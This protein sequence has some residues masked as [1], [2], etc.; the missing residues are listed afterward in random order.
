MA[1]QDEVTKYLATLALEQRERTSDLEARNEAVLEKKL[2]DLEVGPACSKAAGKSQ[3]ENEGPSGIIAGDSGRSTIV[4]PSEPEVVF[5]SD[6]EAPPLQP[7]QRDGGV[8]GAYAVAGTL[9][10]E[11][12]Q[13]P[14]DGSAAD[15]RRSL[16]QSAAPENSGLVEA[17]EVTDRA[18]DELQEAERVARSTEQPKRNFP[19]LQTGLAVVCLLLIVV[20]TVVPLALRSPNNH[21]EETAPETNEESVLDPETQILNILPEATKTRLRR[22]SSAQSMAL[23]W[24]L[25]DPKLPEYIVRHWKVLQRFALV[26]MYHSLGGTRWYNNTGWLSYDVDECSW[27]AHPRIGPPPEVSGG[28][29]GPAVEHRNPCGLPDGGDTGPYKNLWLQNNRLQGTLPPEVSLLSS[30][31]TMSLIVNEIQGTMPSEMGHLTALEGLAIGM[32]QLSGNLPTQLGLL[33]NLTFL[34]VTGQGLSGTVPSELGLL[35][36]EFLLLDDNAFSG[37]MA[38]EL[39]QVPSHYKVFYMANNH[40]HGKLPTELGNMKDVGYLDLFRN[41]LSETIPSET[42]LLTSLIYLTGHI[43]EFSGMMPSELGLL[44]SVELFLWQQNEFTGMIPSELGLWSSVEVLSLSRNEFSG[45]IPSEFGMMSSVRGMDLEANALSGPIP[46]QLGLLSDHLWTFFALE[47]Q[48][49]GSI[50]QE[51][52]DMVASPN[53]SLVIFDVSRNDGLALA[54]GLPDGACW[55]DSTTY[56]NKSWVAENLYFVSYSCGHDCSCPHPHYKE[57]GYIDPY[58]R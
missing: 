18:D 8:P 57:G 2:Q 13:A 24:L 15:D 48:L 7:A 4:N 19:I 39:F 12:D 37:T 40:L 35:P 51:V 10:S 54:D 52:V 55:I 26:T 25:D 9:V 49:T 16:P 31:R 53:S 14:H 1:D 45:P 17:H 32:N 33:S 21:D 30:L 47:N 11:D 5:G 22:T 3:K 41:S 34:E 20:A 28:I 44:P 42:G 38:S 43:N 50:P 46:S 23:Q 36:L 58:A 29:L 6:T 56:S 27:Y